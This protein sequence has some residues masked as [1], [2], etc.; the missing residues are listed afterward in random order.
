MKAPSTTPDVDRSERLSVER[1]GTASFEVR[2]I[3]YAEPDGRTAQLTA[4]PS[5]RL[6]SRR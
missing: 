5:A 1:T 2:V 3:T 6:I 4:S